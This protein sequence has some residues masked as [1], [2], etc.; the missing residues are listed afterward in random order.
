MRQTQKTMKNAGFSLI[1]LLMAM[2]ISLIVIAGVAMAYRSQTKASRTQQLT[3][4]LQQNLRA[5][6]FLLERDTITAGYTPHPF[7]F[8]GAGFTVCTATQMQFTSVVNM[9]G[10]DND[11]DGDIDEDDE[12]DFID[13]QL[14]DSLGDG[15]LDL[16]RQAGGQAVAEN[17]EAIEFFYT[18]THPDLAGGS[19]QTFTP[20][21]LGGIPAADDPLAFITSVTISVL[22]RAAFIDQAYTNNDTYTT[23]SG[24]FWGP[25]NDG[26]RLQMQTITVQCRNNL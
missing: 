26:F 14:F 23:G 8:D 22:A 19:A 16:Q 25:Y 4:A 13:Y 2:A 20:A 7:V 21:G 5:A 17:I 15:D 11:G 3:A 6:L 18:V 24:A 12:I 9:D 10:I 1:E